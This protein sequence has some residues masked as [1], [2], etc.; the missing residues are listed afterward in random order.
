MAKIQQNVK[1]FT[2]RGKA[3][4]WQPSSKLRSQGWK[5]QKLS[6]NR[7]KAIEEAKAINRKLDSWYLNLEDEANNQAQKV[8]TISLLIN[9]FKKSLDFTSK[10][11]TT[12]TFYKGHFKKI[13]DWAGDCPASSISRNAVKAYY[14]KIFAEHP[15]TAN[16]WLRTFR[17]LLY[18]GAGEEKINVNP[19]TRIG[20]KDTLPRDR[21]VGYDEMLMLVAQADKLGLWSIGTGILMGFYLGQRESDLI[22]LDWHKHYMDY[23]D[24]ATIRVKQ[25]KTR[26]WV[27]I[28]IAEPLQKRLN[29]ISDRTGT[30]L[31]MD[32]ENQPYKRDCFCHRFARI[33]QSLIEEHPELSSLQFRDLRR[34]VAV[35]L[36]EAGCS[37][38][39][40]S[41]VT[42]H[43]I[44]TSRQILEVYVPRTGKMAAAAINKLMAA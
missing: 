21:V 23:G 41:A 26:V 1:Y 3:Y 18:W 20:I 19:L 16:G 36:A 38:I 39:E 32:K 13:N 31:K 11:A 7:E 37:E 24:Y 35:R 4:Y 40:I 25:N 30:I 27:E 8:Y 43:R 14:R 6:N 22:K 10:A 42:G 2:Q 17:R 12:Q 29:Q 9:D 33:R 28:P 34:T 44:E 15:Q 5:N